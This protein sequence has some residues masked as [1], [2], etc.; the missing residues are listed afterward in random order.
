MVQFP[1]P[2]GPDDTPERAAYWIAQAAPGARRSLFESYVDSFTEADP[3]F[4]VDAFAARV[5]DQLEL[6]RKNG[7]LMTP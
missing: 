7:E 1:S 5:H 6:R 4:D 2:L 3:A